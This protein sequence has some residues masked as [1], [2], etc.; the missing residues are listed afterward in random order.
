[1]AKQLKIAIVT[2]EAVPYAKTGGLADVAGILPVELKKLGYNAVLIL[3]YYKRIH[4][5]IKTLRVSDDLYTTTGANNLKVYFVSN[6]KYFD[7]EQLY[8]TSAGDYPD[9]AYRFGFFC[10]RVLDLFVQIG[11]HPDIIHINDW[12]TALIPYFLK[13]I[14]QNI[15]FYKGIKTLFTIHNIAYQGL[16]QPDVLP[17]LGLG[18]DAFT[19]YGNGIEFYGMVNFLKAGLISADAV[20]TVSKKYSYEIQ[21]KEYG[22]G[23]DGV[24]REQRGHIYGIL[25]GADYNQWN[26]ETDKYIIK[27][28]NI[29]NI[30]KKSECRKDLL[31]EFQLINTNDSTPVIGM[32]SRLAD[33]KGFDI[34]TECIPNF[35]KLDLR[36]VLLGTGEEKYHRLFKEIQKKY[37]GRFSARIEFNDILA[38]KIEAGSDMFLMPSRYE[39]CGL[40]QIYSLKYGTVP[41]VRATGGL[42]DTIENFNALTGQGNGFK[43]AVYSSA[44][45]LKKVKEALDLFKNKRL[46][47]EVVKNGM[48][49]DF[50]WL[51]S[52]MEYADLYNKIIHYKQ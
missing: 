30:E 19:P 39:P 37:P 47:R 26:P 32:I 7:R 13:T 29:E 4:R 36:L 3:P 12:Q 25:N 40:N 45:L 17:G 16:F 24:I 14:K 31:K 33:Q 51:H 43:F 35:A 27:R 20:S 2:S 49:A 48:K 21:T 52:A 1:M 44:D 8:G 50:S 41:I 34:L 46:W 23:L 5:K 11:F 42:D 18:R 6:S 15:P 28:Y 38:H 22:Y 9:N 10:K